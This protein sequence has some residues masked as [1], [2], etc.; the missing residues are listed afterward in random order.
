MGSFLFACN[1]Y[2][3][4]V[5]GTAQMTARAVRKAMTA[6]T[7]CPSEI[8]LKLLSSTRAVEIDVRKATIAPTIAFAYWLTLPNDPSFNGL[9]T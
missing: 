1:A 8:S 5:F 9:A 6:T 7:H 3:G 2:S 4:G